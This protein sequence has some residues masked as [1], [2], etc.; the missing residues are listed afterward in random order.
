MGGACIG[1]QWGEER[2]LAQGWVI[3][4][5]YG[6]PPPLHKVFLNSY[7]IFSVSVIQDVTVCDFAVNGTP[8]H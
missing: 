5:W 6:T 2:V 8:D 1:R 7:I 4:M 3:E